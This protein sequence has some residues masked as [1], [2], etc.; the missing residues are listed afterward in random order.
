MV[1]LLGGT[2]ATDLAELLT[3]SRAAIGATSGLSCI[4]VNAD[5][6]ALGDAMPVAAEAL[7]RAAFVPEVD[8]VRVEWRPTSPVP[9]MSVRLTMRAAGE[10]GPARRSTDC[11]R[12]ATTT[13]SRTGS[14]SGS[15]PLEP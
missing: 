7:A 11:T 3:R 1:D 9:P 6:S 13:V 14:A 8:R 10:G 12:R 2:D 5:V 4:Q 15:T